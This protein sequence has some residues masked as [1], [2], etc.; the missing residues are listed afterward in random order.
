MEET[1][2]FSIRNLFLDYLLTQFY[3]DHLKKFQLRY[4]FDIAIR[5]YIRLQNISLQFNPYLSIR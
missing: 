1:F 5:K 4:Q 3:D 2:N